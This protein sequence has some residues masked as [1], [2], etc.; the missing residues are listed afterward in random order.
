MRSFNDMMRD[1]VDGGRNEQD[2]ERVGRVIAEIAIIDDDRALLELTLLAVREAGFSAVGF[3]EP[4]DA[5]MW[6][7]DADPTCLVADLK[8]PGVEGLD[9]V[10]RFLL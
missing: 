5:L 4:L 2:A 6:A 8:M 7:S 3:H 1:G 10:C 9:F